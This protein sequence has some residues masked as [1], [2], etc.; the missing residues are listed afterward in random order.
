M[1]MDM[2]RRRG[3][4]RDGMDMD[5]PDM[6]MSGEIVIDMEGTK[7]YITMGA[8]LIKAS[9]AVALVASTLF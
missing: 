6:S 7:I 5:M 8:N 4:R 9:A 3:D 1:E 2:D